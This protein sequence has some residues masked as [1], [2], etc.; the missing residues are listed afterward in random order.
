MTRFL[1]RDIA[2]IEKHNKFIEEQDFSF[3]FIWFQVQSFAFIPKF[4]F[5]SIFI[6]P[7]FWLCYFLN[8]FVVFKLKN[9]DPLVTISY[10]EIGWTYEWSYVFQCGLN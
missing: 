8:A 6:M 7:I 2:M 1:E 10:N 9:E 4:F 3:D 5:V